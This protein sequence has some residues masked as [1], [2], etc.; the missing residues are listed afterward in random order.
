LLCVACAAEGNDLHLLLLLL[1]LLFWCCR[2]CCCCCCTAVNASRLYSRRQI[3]G[4]P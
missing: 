1:P 3:V 2:R 4:P